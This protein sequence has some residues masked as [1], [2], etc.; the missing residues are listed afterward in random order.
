MHFLNST[1][2]CCEPPAYGSELLNSLWPRDA[3]WWHW[4]GSTLIQAMACFL[5]APSHYLNQYWLIIKGVPWNSP[6]SSFKASTHEPIHDD[7]IKWK[8]FPRYWPFVRG[9]H[10]SSVNSL[11]KGQWRG[12]LMFSLICTRINCWVNDGEAG[13]F[14][15]HH[16]HY[17]VTVM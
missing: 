6:M 12:A 11:H 4:F 14:R 1:Q 15:R 3:I 10:R 13:D 16:A 5:A 8:H 7:V 17:D 9:I 2:F